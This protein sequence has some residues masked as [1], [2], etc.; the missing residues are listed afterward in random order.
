MGV[1]VD[2]DLKFTEHVQIQTT[3]ANKLL[4]MIRRTFGFIDDV[5]LPLLY[6]AIVRP[7][8]E[9]CNTVWHPKWKKELEDLESIQ[10]RATKLVPGLKDKQYP[11][12][13]KAM[14][15]PSLYYRRARGDMIECFKYLSGMYKVSTEFL[16]L[17]TREGSRGHSRKLNKCAAKKP[18]RSNFFNRRITN[19][20]NSLPEE[21]VMAP[22][23]DAFKSR[24]D[25]TWKD[26]HYVQDSEWYKN[27]KLTK[28]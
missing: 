20:W 14:K 6:R 22:S 5:T 7:H 21:V 25:K 26:Y 28:D 10:R 23:I 18:C 15:L 4:G 13:L 1:N 11:D 9:Y 8:L 27:P 19:A 16:E 2:A 24:L 12:R 17:D 3:K